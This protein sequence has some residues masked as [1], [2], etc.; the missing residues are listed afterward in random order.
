M[1]QTKAFCLGLSLYPLPLVEY[2][3]ERRRVM[4]P[5]PIENISLVEDMPPNAVL[6]VIDFE[7]KHFVGDW[8]LGVYIETGNGS[9]SSE[10]TELEF[11]QKLVWPRMRECYP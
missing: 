8:R 9:F 11:F 2:F 5:K 6:E 3:P 1:T 7:L 10:R 4:L